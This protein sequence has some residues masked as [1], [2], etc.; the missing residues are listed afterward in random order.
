MPGFAQQPRAFTMPGIVG[1]V[2]GVLEVYRPRTLTGGNAFLENDVIIDPAAK[3][4]TS[5]S[6]EDYRF[7]TQRPYQIVHHSPDGR[8]RVIVRF[9]VPKGNLAVGWT[10]KDVDDWRVWGYSTKG[11]DWKFDLRNSDYPLGITNKG[12]VV[13]TEPNVKYKYSEGL[14]DHMGLTI[15]SME[16][17]WLFNPKTGERKLITKDLLYKNVK[18][19]L[20]M[21]MNQ[22]GETFTIA[23]YA[24]GFIQCNTYNV[25]TGEHWNITV[26][27]GTTFRQIGNSLALV[28]EF[29]WSGDAN[30]SV[31]RVI[32]LKDGH[33]LLSEPASDS[34]GFGSDTWCHNITMY[35]DE[36]YFMNKLNYSIARLKPRDGKMVMAGIVPLDTAGL[37]LK[38]RSYYL[39]VLND[40]F[41][42]IPFNLEFPEDQSPYPIF[43]YFFDRTGSPQLAMRPFFIQPP[44]AGAIASKAA[45]EKAECDRAIK[46]SPFPMGALVRKKGAGDCK[47]SPLIWGIEC[48]YNSYTTVG[49][50]EPH[51]SFC[52]AADY[53][54]C[55]A[56]PYEICTKCK[57]TG[58]IKHWETVSD[59]G[60]KQTNFN[61]YVR[62]PNG[63]KGVALDGPCDKCGGKKMVRL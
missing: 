28:H 4:L 47:T 56:G 40:Y 54:L 31:I 52:K 23:Y 61:V 27:V 37:L 33:E 24:N 25:H 43:G 57:G 5:I 38:K 1:Q 18:S 58:T 50:N 20:F 10:K 44:S 12:E 7:V 46:A 30:T 59:D 29:R 19:E 55:D 17:L 51:M 6:Q 8:Y 2:T 45:A 32:D 16:G 42:L 39:G 41:A 60:W 62:N 14:H 13:T 11:E 36:L 35:G 48:G 9:A 53:E 21:T 15:T 34:A 22:A 26:P 3:T 49:P 63:V